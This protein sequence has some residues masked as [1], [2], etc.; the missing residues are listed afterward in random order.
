MTLKATGPG[1]VKVFPNIDPYMPIEAS[2][3][4]FDHDGDRLKQEH[5]S[6]LNSEIVPKLKS[7]RYGLWISGRASKQGSVGTP[8]VDRWHRHTE[9]RSSRFSR[10]VLT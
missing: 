2:M 10:G 4:N 3:Y 6:F 9:P 5:A 8:Q 1:Q 7:G